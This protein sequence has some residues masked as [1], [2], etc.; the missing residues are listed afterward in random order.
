MRIY[1]LFLVA[2]SLQQARSQSPFHY[3]KGR[4]IYF[5]SKADI[6]KEGIGHIYTTGA[7]PEYGYWYFMDMDLSDLDHVYN[8]R[9]CDR[10]DDSSQVPPLDSLVARSELYVHTSFY[11]FTAN[12]LHRVGTDGMGAN[13]MWTYRY[14]NGG[15][16]AYEDCK[17]GT[18]TTYKK[19]A[20]LPNGLVHYVVCCSEMDFDGK[21][22]KGKAY[23]D[24]TYYVYDAQHWVRG[25]KKRRY[26]VPGSLYP[27]LQRPSAAIQRSRGTRLHQYSPF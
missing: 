10:R 12:R 22:L 21:R 2:C 8:N 9:F 26:Q 13:C 27:D 11:E 6:K 7:N 17:Y 25:F 4:A 3:G 23:G 16:T 1:L 20:Y 5:M 15:A 14:K 19:V 18:F 24:T